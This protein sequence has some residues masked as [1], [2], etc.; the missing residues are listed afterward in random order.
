MARNVVAIIKRN[1]GNLQKSNPK[2]ITPYLPSLLESKSLLLR[3]VDEMAIRLIGGPSP[4]F[5]FASAWD[6]YAW[7]SNHQHIHRIR[8][9]L[10]LINA[11]DDPIVLNLPSIELDEGYSVLVLTKG[12]GHLGW[13][14]HS[15][16]SANGPQRWVRKPVL[17]WLKATAED[18]VSRPT[19]HESE[20][21]G[22]FVREVGRPD[23]AY[24]VISSGIPVDLHVQQS[25]TD[26]HAGL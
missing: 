19:R 3:D 4:P 7:A 13:F 15:L 26:L 11:M 8:R 22:G 21:V 17:E 23:I 9:P 1:L 10:L 24:Q 12:G 5:P 20:V 2:I 6:Y 25:R 18:L 14:D 16:I